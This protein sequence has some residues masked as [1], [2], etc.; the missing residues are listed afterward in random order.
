MN[1]PVILPVLL[2]ER[3]YDIHIGS[4]LL[5]Q[6]AELL[7]FS[8]EGR[9]CFILTDTH[10]GHY[11]PVLEKALVKGGGTA[12]TLVM[13]PGEAT[14]SYDGL[15][16]V[17]DW[18][19]DNRADRQSVLFSLGGGVIGDLGGLAAAVALR[20]ISYV[21]VPTT[22]LAQVDSA[23]GGKTAIDTKQGKNL[24][25]AFYQPRAVI[26]DLDTLDTLSEREM[27]AGYAEIVKY[28][29]IRDAAFFA[30][31]EENGKKVLEKNK[32]ALSHAIYESCKAKAAI[33]ALDETET[34]DVRALL[35]F[36]H[37]F[38]HAF[39]KMLNYDGR[40]LHGEA[41][42][43]G[44]GMAFDLSVALGHCPAAQ[45]DKAKTHMRALGLK[46]GADVSGVTV[47]GILEAMKSDKKTENGKMN[48]ILA[49]AIGDT[50][51]VR[52]VPPAAVQAVIEK[53]LS[54]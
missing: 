53:N 54:I 13:T 10:A 28:G 39:E 20:G 11:A 16:K 29:F 33:V 35:N 31:L 45:A 51:V 24:V 6:T 41:V 34:N 18:L 40:L 7:P 4:G 5:A 49:R 26:A 42:A 36:G 1:T 15:I 44:M 37:T 50:F 3:G 23:V 32:I 52:D 27:R 30:W 38:G 46:T 2:G 43:I 22:L 48:F 21:Q 25:G 47:A 9:R 19:L 8:L 14:K 17:L 12:F